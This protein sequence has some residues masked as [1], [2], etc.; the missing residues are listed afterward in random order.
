MAKQ[1]LIIENEGLIAG[2]LSKSLRQKGYQI[3]VLELEEAQKRVRRRKA[4]LVLLEAPATAREAAETC[5]SLRDLTTAPIIALV[6]S[7][8]ELGDTEGI[9]YIIKPLDFRE[10]LAAVE[11]TLNRQRKLPKRTLRVLRYGGL[12]L[13]LR[14]RR[15]TKGKKRYRLT[16]KEFLLLKMLMSNPGQVL[17]HKVIMKKVWDTDYLDDLRTL[18]VHI[19]WLRT[20]IED[21]PKHPVL[22]RTVRGVGYRFEGKS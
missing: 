10:L 14:L 16:P 13:D 19:S 3:T 12:R 11:N 15:L 4:S 7:P 20:K 21:N 5:R 22:L 6:E 8:A 9:E 18:Y 17:S 1:I 2:L